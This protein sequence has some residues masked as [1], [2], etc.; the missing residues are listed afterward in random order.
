MLHKNETKSFHQFKLLLILPFLALFLW[1]FNI[2]EDIKYIETTP[3][4]APSFFFSENLP[5]N[6]SINSEKNEL[7]PA[8]NNKVIYSESEAKDNTITVSIDKNTTD[9][10]LKKLSKLFKNN[11]KATLKFSGVKR[12]S[13]GEITDIKVNMKTDKSSANFNETDSDGINKFTISFDSKKGS[14]SIGNN[15]PHNMHFTSED[16]NNFVY[17][18][19]EGG[20]NKVKTWVS[21][22]GKTVHKYK[23]DIDEDYEDDNHE[24]IILKEGDHDHEGDNEFIFIDE[25]GNI[26]KDHGLKVIKHDGN[27]MFFMDGDNDSLIIIDG[28][29]ATKKQME[30]LVTGKIINIEIIKGEVAIKKYGKKAKNGVILINTKEN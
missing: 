8:I 13:K 27:N 6:L 24:I 2:K 21:E 22:D 20:H 29:E 9:A 25:K 28:K 15:N 5:K 7:I 10:E 16:G 11:Y 3:E 26:T 30:D 12:N 18:S 23:Y 19:S 1:S 4:D 14:I 17:S